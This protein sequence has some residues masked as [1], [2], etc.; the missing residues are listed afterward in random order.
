MR[1]V[2]S[3]GPTRCLCVNS[4]EVLDMNSRNELMTAFAG[5]IKTKK[6]FHS[7]QKETLS[8]HLVELVQSTRP[9]DK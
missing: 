2:H 3:R 7:T 1:A 9:V 5:R 4:H 6:K 8:Y